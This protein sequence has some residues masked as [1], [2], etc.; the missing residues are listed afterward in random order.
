MSLTSRSRDVDWGSLAK[1]QKTYP[2]W[3]ARNPMSGFADLAVTHVHAHL[4]FSIRTNMAPP[5]GTSMR[6]HF[7]VV[8]EP[9]EKCRVLTVNMPRG[10]VY[11][12]RGTGETIE[13]LIYEIQGRFR[14][15]S[16]INFDPLDIDIYRVSEHP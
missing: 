11:P 5:L 8:G 10:E 7:F 12:T 3:Q 4:R 13:K 9:N 2:G 1:A 15:T 16:L 14:K 6:I